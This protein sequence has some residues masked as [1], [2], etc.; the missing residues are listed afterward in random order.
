[1]LIND[2]AEKLTGWTQ[3]QA[4]G[5]SMEEVFRLVDSHNGEQQPLD[6]IDRLKAQEV[7]ELGNQ[8]LVCRDGQQ[9]IIDATCARIRSRSQRF[10]GAVLVFRDITERLRLEQELIRT[11]KLESLGVLAGESPMILTIC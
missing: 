9:R 3:C 4:V 1:M 10:I 6:L 7:V 11:S 5:N 2:V 8:V